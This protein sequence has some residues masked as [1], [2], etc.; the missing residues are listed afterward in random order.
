[1]DFQ[2]TDQVKAPTQSN[3]FSTAAL[4]FGI[5]SVASLCLLYFS[6]MFAGLAILFALLSKGYERKMNGY[7]KAGLITAVFGLTCSLTALSALFAF[8]FHVMSTTELTG[9]D[10]DF[11]RIYEQ[12]G[13]TMYG[14]RFDDLLK[15]QYGD[16]FDIEQFT[17]GGTP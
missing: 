6:P 2:G 15:Q 7:A 17:K 10:S 12:V 9:D 4:L 13:E 16:D 5:L 11:W 14:D 1:M 8:A 3:A